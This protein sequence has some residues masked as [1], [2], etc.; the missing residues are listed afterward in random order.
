MP[1]I[2]TGRPRGRPPY[3]D[4]LTPAEQRVLELV[5]AGLSNP[6]IADRLGITLGAVKFHV[7][8]MLSKLHL[9]DRHGLAAW[10][11]APAGHIVWRRLE[12]A[13]ATAILFFPRRAS[14]TV[15]LGA[16][17]VAVAGGV[18]LIARQAPRGNPN[19]VPTASSASPPAVGTHAAIT[20]TSDLS[21]SAIVTTPP[22]TASPTG[23]DAETSSPASTL[24]GPRTLANG[25]VRFS[26]KMLRIAAREG[27][28]GEVTGEFRLNSLV[29]TL[30][31]ADTETFE[32]ETRLGG[33]VTEDPDGRGLAVIDG[34][35]G[36]GDRVAL[37]IRNHVWDRQT[38]AFY[39]N[40]GAGSCADL[41]ASVPNVL[42]GGFFG[43]IGFGD[44]IET[45]GGYFEH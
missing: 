40:E 5:R 15:V 26:G 23:T 34:R 37:L 8:N 44:H 9:D 18:V 2:R 17:G 38:V 45:V 43:A 29:V 1:Y 30:E 19:P 20:S 3:P 22:G 35:A 36:V 7:S 42:D 31:C 21:G 24:S 33:R 12:R 6:E 41:L 11:P 4:P 39:S 25:V 27:E 13:M 10:Q 28:D 32:G 14:H 16:V